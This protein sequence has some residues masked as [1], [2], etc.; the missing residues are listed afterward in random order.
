MN[1]YMKKLHIKILLY[2]L[3]IEVGNF[4]CYFCDN[5]FLSITFTSIDNFYF[6]K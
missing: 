4:L 6:F 5:L 2:L 3:T 1:S